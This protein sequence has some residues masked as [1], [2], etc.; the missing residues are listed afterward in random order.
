MDAFGSANNGV[1]SHD[2]VLGYGAQCR[3]Y[4]RGVPTWCV[5]DAAGFLADIYGP[6]FMSNAET[7]KY[8]GFAFK[9]P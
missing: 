3:C 9:C 4:F 6:N 5:E 1:V 7:K 2:N 8:G